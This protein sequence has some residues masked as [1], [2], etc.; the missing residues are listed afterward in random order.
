MTNLSKLEKVRLRR[1]QGKAHIENDLTSSEIT[2]PPEADK[3]PTVSESIE[4]FYQNKEVL[5]KLYPERI[6]EFE[7]LVSNHK[8][9]LKFLEFEK[10]YRLIS[11]LESKGYEINSEDAERV[12]YY[13]TNNPKDNDNDE[14]LDSLIQSLNLT[15]PNRIKP[16]N[17][18]FKSKNIESSPNHS[19]C[20]DI[21]TLLIKPQEFTNKEDFVEITQNHNNKKINAYTTLTIPKPENID[22]GDTTFTVLK[23]FDWKDRKILRLIFTEAVH[24]EGKFPISLK[25]VLKQIGE[26]ETGGKSLNEK[27]EDLRKRFLK[28]RAVSIRWRYIAGKKIDKG[29]IS[30]GDLFIIQTSDFF[31]RKSK[32]SFDI[33][34]NIRLGDWFDTNKNLIKE[35]TR[36]PKKLITINTHRHWLSYAIGEK[37]CV[38]LRIN[39]EKILNTKSTYRVPIKLSVKSLLDE[40]LTES[41]IKEALEDNLKSSRLKLKIL[42]ETEFLESYLNWQFQW[43]GLT[44]NQNFNDFYNTVSFNCMVDP[45][46]ESEILGEKNVKAIKP[47]SSKVPLTIEGDLVKE[48]RKYLKMTQIIFGKSIGYEQ[49]YISKIERNTELASEDFIKSLYKKYTQEIV[50][51][52]K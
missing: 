26:L 20:I 7:R 12:F 46:L 21:L 25:W 8:N 6:A 4:T 9:T 35:F 22:I 50:K 48:L 16:S 41:E 10:V 30:G 28:Y 11:S 2:P 42:D 23:C 43:I 47:K 32:N 44:D 39:K 49:S 1:L 18:S 45:E 38:L 17:K 19:T 13:V 31:E 3:M 24:H 40:I 33:E 36:I 52:Q 15:K 34:L 5:S 14:Y 51:I 29:N 27:L 37:I